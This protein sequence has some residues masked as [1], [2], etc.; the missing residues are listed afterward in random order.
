MAILLAAL[1]EGAQGITQLAEREGLTQ[2]TAT[3][4]V[5]GLEAQGLVRRTRRND[6]RRFVTVEITPAGRIELRRLRTN[7]RAALKHSLA[8]LDDAELAGLAAA[9]ETLQRVIEVLVD[10]AAH[11]S[12][13]RVLAR[14]KPPGQ[15]AAAEG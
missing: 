14:P 1:E 3:R 2:S 7:W 8:A 12:A 10:T 11:D 15:P 4:V 9:S 6:D 13:S 5:I